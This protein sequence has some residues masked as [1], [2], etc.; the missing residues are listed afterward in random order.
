[1]NRQE[2]LRTGVGHPTGL[3]LTLSFLG[4]AQSGKELAGDV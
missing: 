1:M 4:R 3:R 2:G